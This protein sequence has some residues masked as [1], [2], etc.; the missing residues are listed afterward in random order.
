MF[1]YY[2]IT[3]TFFPYTVYADTYIYCMHTKYDIYI[4]I[5]NFYTLCINACDL[6]HMEALICTPMQ[7]AV[8]TLQG[9]TGGL[10]SCMQTD[11]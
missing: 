2:K 1:L 4:F 9:G 11:F 6:I 10:C 3:D 5:Y 7:R 8:Y